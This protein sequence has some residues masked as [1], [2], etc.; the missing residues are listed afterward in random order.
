[1]VARIVPVFRAFVPCSWSL[2]S[3]NPSGSRRS[4]NRA[5]GSGVVGF[6]GGVSIRI[7]RRDDG[8][9]PS[10]SPQLSIS[11]FACVTT[12]TA[13]CVVTRVSVLYVTP[14][15]STVCAAACHIANAVQYPHMASMS[16]TVTMP[17]PASWLAISFHFLFAAGLSHL[18]GLGGS[19][20]A[21]CW[22]LAA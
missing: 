7:R 13:G 16:K 17:A 14:S 15:F 12:S 6:G 4:K 8:V 2:H 10:F 11:R 20:G 3:S 19:I 18:G 21:A 5:F 22:R 1:P 9:S